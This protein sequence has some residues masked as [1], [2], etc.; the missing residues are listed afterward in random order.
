MSYPYELDVMLYESYLGVS[1]SSNGGGG[2]GGGE[3]DPSDDIDTM[4]SKGFA[5]RINN[6][7]IPDETYG[8]RFDTSEFADYRLED[9]FSNAVVGF[10]YRPNGS[11]ED[12]QELPFYKMGGVEDEP[13]YYALETNN[14]SG[15]TDNNEIY[16]ISSNEIGSFDWDL[17]Y[18][19]PSYLHNNQMGNATN[20]ETGQLE[21]NGT[22]QFTDE[23]HWVCVLDSPKTVYNG[24]N[25]F[26]DLK[27]VTGTYADWITSDVVAYDTKGDEVALVDDLALTINFSGI[28]GEMDIRIDFWYNQEKNMA[29]GVDPK[30]DGKD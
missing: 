28:E 6:Y 17:Q 26:F 1:I 30:D 27:R 10:K 9:S 20:Q 22:L 14:I 21:Q 13:L 4:L 12:A 5:V 18:P 29:H 3:F 25:S 16:L 23:T 19:L 2:G 8:A 7:L 24:S 15:G 11:S